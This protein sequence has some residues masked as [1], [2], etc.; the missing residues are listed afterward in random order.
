[1]RTCSLALVIALFGS[2]ASAQISF[3]I[4]LPNAIDGVRDAADF[5]LFA[6]LFPQAGATF[7]PDID[8]VMTAPQL[9]EAGGYLSDEFDGQKKLAETERPSID[10]AMAQLSVRAIKP[11]SDRRTRLVLEDDANAWANAVSDQEVHLG[12]RF[13][14]G[15]ALGSLRESTNGQAVFSQ[16]LGAFLGA[17]PDKKIEDTELERRARL[18]FAAARNGKSEMRTDDDFEAHYNQ[19]VALLNGLSGTGGGTAVF[20]ELEKHLAAAAAGGPIS[21]VDGMFMNDVFMQLGFHFNPALNFVVSH[22]LGHVMLGHLPILANLP[23]ADKQQRESDADAF[24]IALLVYDIPGD[25]EVEEKS[26]YALGLGD[27]PDEDDER[28]GFGYAHSLR[29]GF[30]LAGA[31]NEID[32]KCNYLGAEERISQLERWRTFLM[33]RRTAA[34]EKAL[35]AFREAPPYVYVGDIDEGLSAANRAA[36]I[37][38]RYLL[39]HAGPAPQRSITHK[40]TGLTFGFAIACPNPRPA[41]LANADF[42]LQLGVSTAGQLA[43]EYG[44][45]VPV[46]MSS[47]TLEALQPAD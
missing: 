28:L 29:Y 37:R 26:L 36:M 38:R 46:V 39:C 45:R 1:M 5:R 14:R 2:G 13:L 3:P 16:M 15:L 41:V 12:A 20:A 10:A 23:C 40:L 32:A 21:G 35:R 47:E 33:A 6:N 22:E 18:F 24:A 27:P 11:T 30:A 9:K 19:S 17:T 42:R 8:S 34:Y 43:A 4:E 31:S 44:T 7:R 25:T